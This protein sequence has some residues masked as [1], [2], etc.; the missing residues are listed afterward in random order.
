[1]F[2]MIDSRRSGC[3]A[4]RPSIRACLRNCESLRIAVFLYMSA[5]FLGFVFYMVIEAR[6][7]TLKSNIYGGGKL[8]NYFDSVFIFSHACFFV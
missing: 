2:T 4:K 7:C 6:E 5:V 3:E 8:K 1:M